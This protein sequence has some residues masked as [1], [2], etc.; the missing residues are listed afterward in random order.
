MIVLLKIIE[1]QLIGVF[2][3]EYRK[4]DKLGIETSLLGFGC[5]RLPL[6]E[7][8]SDIDE[9]AA[10]DIIRYGIDHGINYIDTAYMYHDGASEVLVGKALKDGYREKVF[11]A[12]KMPIWY[13]KDEDEMCNLFDEQF[14]RLDVD[15]IEMYLV[16]NLTVSF[17]QKAKDLNL[18]PFLE[19][20]KE[21]GK[22]KYIGFS[23]HDEYKLFEEIVDYYDWDFCQ[24]QLNYMDV[25]YQAGLKGLKYASSKDIPVIIMEPLKGGRLA[26]HPP[27]SVEKLIK[28][29]NNDW[30]F[31]EWGFKWLTDF[32]DVKLILSGMNDFSQVKENIETFKH[33]PSNVMNKEDYVIIDKIRNEYK[34]LL[35]I[36]CTDCK[37]CLP[38]PV[39][40]QIPHLFDL[41][42]NVFLYNDLSGSQV[43][44]NKWMDAKYHAD[45]CTKCGQCEDAC[46]QHLK[47]M[48]L[49]E[50][51][52]EELFQE[53]KKKKAKVSGK[54]KK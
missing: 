14:E 53:D 48:G 42:N 24:I 10:I 30:S 16:H 15:H 4:W 44:Y 23:F 36:D 12:D 47:I 32:P 38:C 11:L 35:K 21:K 2:D 41:Y 5:M 9:K 7:G 13:C 43:S 37:Y 19:E 20:M 22:I 27:E 17:W 39:K 50:N 26:A 28:S 34:K 8:T 31:V 29:S 54:R 18:L 46:P 49:L 51:V 52:H 25:D 33:M 6:I 40:I 1:K 45:K 3:L